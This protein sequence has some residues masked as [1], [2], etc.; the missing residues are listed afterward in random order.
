MLEAGRQ[1]YR[2]AEGVFRSHANRG[3]E[4]FRNAEEV[5]GIQI[6]RIPEIRPGEEGC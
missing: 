1:P 4:R 3:L 5:V 2:R 6:N